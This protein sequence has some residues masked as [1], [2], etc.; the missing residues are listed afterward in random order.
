MRHMTQ[1][2]AP[3]VLLLI[4]LLTVPNLVVVAQSQAPVMPPADQP[5]LFEQLHRA[6][7][8]LGVPA[9]E[10][11]DPERLYKQ[12]IQEIAD[13]H[14][15]L[16]TKPGANEIDPGTGMPVDRKKEFLDRWGTPA[17]PLK[18]LADADA[19]IT[20]A[21][22][23]LGGRFDSYLV[24]K[25]VKAEDKD[26]DSKSVGIGVRIELKD[27]DKLLEKL[28]RDATGD[29]VR[30]AL[31]ISADHPLLIY[32]FKDSPADKAGLKEGDSVIKVDGV[33]LRGKTMA[34]AVGLIR[35]TKGT[36][37]EIVVERKEPDGTVKQV[38]VTVTRNEYYIPAASLRDLG[39]GTFV[40]RLDNFVAAKAAEEV[41]GYLQEVVKKG[42]KKL[43][44]DLRDNGGGRLDHAINIVMYM[45]PEGTIVVQEHR[46]KG[47]LE[48]YETHTNV[49]WQLLLRTEPTRR[50]VLP[51]TQQRILAIP[52]E[53]PIVVLVNEHS[54]SA[55]ELVS[56]T[57]QFNG[58]AK[59]VGKRTFGKGV[60]QHLIDL[61]YGRRLHITSF[62]FLPA[63][64]R[65]DWVGIIPDLEV[66]QAQ[67]GED[68]QLQAA[69]KLVSDMYERGVK[70]RAERQ[71]REEQIRQ[72][73][74]RQWQ[75]QMERRR[76]A[77]EKRRQ[78]KKSD[79]Q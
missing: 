60:G 59:I 63:N 14:I 48:Y 19:A 12:A 50:G 71:S 20:E 15:F 28:P 74:R 40:L 72:E 62:N 24:P 5:P 65:I 2:R 54:A 39:D 21:L 22:E 42:G 64:R 47:H 7:F 53:M 34:D 57:L 29:Q 27:S 51:V 17:R 33:D 78:E 26:F 10:K 32:P 36:K 73:N 13:R 49:T 44:L 37:V 55:S 61:P 45:L 56:G 69:T 8:P 25:E 31:V 16:A 11:P 9:P 68:G 3:V 43:I 67:A 38:T 58:R 75:E 66:E 46:E 76:Q 18:T 23:S 52:P 41:L 35:G 79:G 4:A 6:I 1:T 30:Q 77:E 70:E